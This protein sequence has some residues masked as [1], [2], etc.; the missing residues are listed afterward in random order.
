MVKP[1]SKRRRRD[2]REH[3]CVEWVD[4]DTVDFW[5]L[6]WVVREERKEARNPGRMAAGWGPRRGN[7]DDLL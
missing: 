2:G 5:G 7:V 6:R 4:G 1:G 3:R